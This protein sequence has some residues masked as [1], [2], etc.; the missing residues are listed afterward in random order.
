[1]PPDSDLDQT[2]LSGVR[3]VL[4]PGELDETYA[5]SLFLAYADNYVKTWRHQQNRKYITYCTAVSGRP[6]HGHKIW[7]NMDVWLLRYASGLGLRPPCLW[8]MSTICNHVTQINQ[9]VVQIISNTSRCLL[10][11]NMMNRIIL[12]ATL[13]H[14]C[15]YIPTFE[16]HL[17]NSCNQCVLSREFLECWVRNSAHGQMSPSYLPLPLNYD[18]LYSTKVRQRQ[19][20]QKDDIQHEY[21]RNEFK[22]HWSRIRSDYTHSGRKFQLS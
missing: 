2:T 5:S 6:T 1:M 7:C 18:H 4:P 10:F 9:W 17:S 11:T 14:F 21:E 15:K 20:R 16:C 3:L 12:I 13:I 19:T 22:T 8:F